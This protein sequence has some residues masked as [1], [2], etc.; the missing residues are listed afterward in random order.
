M[1]LEADK[2]LVVELSDDSPTTLMF[3]CGVRSGQ[4]LA[5]WSDQKTERGETLVV[6]GVIFEKLWK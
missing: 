4:S 6:Q 2:L 3:S 1:F 5:I